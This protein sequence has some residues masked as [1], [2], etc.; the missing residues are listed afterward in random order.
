MAKA[1]KDGEG[2]QD[3]EGQEP[4]GGAQTTGP[5]DPVPGEGSEYEVGDLRP[6]PVS[7]HD[8]QD[9]A[10][11]DEREKFHSA[12][13]EFSDE[14]AERNPVAV[15]DIPGHKGGPGA[16]DEQG[17]ERPERNEEDFTEQSGHEGD[18]RGSDGPQH[19]QGEGQVLG[20]DGGSDE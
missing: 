5:G 3:G 12:M 8:D 16:P 17:L 11:S 6:E 9:E 20:S 10:V 18:I 2:V 7:V 19:L 15:A 13:R 4:S 14:Y 1:K